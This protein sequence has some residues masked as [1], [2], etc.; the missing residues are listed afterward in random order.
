MLCRQDVLIHENMRYIL[1]LFQLMLF[2]R[3]HFY[4]I[5]KH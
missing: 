5:N 3:N 2:N 1:H 4:M